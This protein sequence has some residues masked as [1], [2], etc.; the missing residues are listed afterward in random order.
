VD[1]SPEERLILEEYRKRAPW[2][3]LSALFPKQLAFVKDP[4][5]WKTALCTRRAGKSTAIEHY[6]LSTAMKHPGSV[7]LYIALT[8]L[9][10]KR[11]VWPDLIA[12]DAKHNLGLKFNHSELT[13]TLKNGSTI[14]V[15]GASDP[16]DIEKFRGGKYKLVAIDE[17]GSFGD[18]LS[19][20]VD[21]VLSPALMDQL[22]TLCLLGTPSAIYRDET[23]PRPPNGPGP[24]LFYAATTF[25]TSWSHHRWSVL[26]NPHI[27]HAKEEIERQMKSRGWDHN[28]PAYRREW[29]G[30]WARSSEELVYQYDPKANDYDKLPDLGPGSAWTYILS[31]DT[32]TRDQ[33]AFI[34]S[35]FAEDHPNWYVVEEFAKSGMVPDQIAEHIKNF[36]RKYNPER[37]VMDCG[38]Q[39]LALA[40][41][42]RTTHQLPIT[43]AE[44]RE[45]LAFIDFFNGDLRTGKIKVRSDS[46]LVEEWRNLTYDKKGKEDQKAKNDLADAALYGYRWARQYLYRDPVP[47]P[48]PPT[49]DEQMAKYWRKLEREMAGELRRQRDWEWYSQF[50]G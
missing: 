44:K 4:A 19:S 24:S 6:L 20:L 2:D 34:V 28:S 50:G 38:A 18:H 16:S 47:P 7:N 21:E 42:F 25:D 39:G 8:R 48:P 13:V 29:L 17:A 41:H 36:M 3:P 27:P 30:E 43:P 35:A 40:E 26:D 46:R 5:R 12:I 37:V 33:T 49:P 15:S 1:L 14:M 32:G 9:S 23:T 11:L 45:K 31:V 10:A 22:G